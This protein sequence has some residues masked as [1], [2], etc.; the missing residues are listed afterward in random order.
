MSVSLSFSTQCTRS[1]RVFFTYT[2]H[3]LFDSFS[4][5]CMHVVQSS[6]TSCMSSCKTRDSSCLP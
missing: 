6:M 2:A 5:Y 3:I 1:E 4:L